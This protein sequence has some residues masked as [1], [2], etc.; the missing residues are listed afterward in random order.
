MIY[1]IPLSGG[2]VATLYGNIDANTALEIANT[3]NKK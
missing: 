1:V 2:K 3:I